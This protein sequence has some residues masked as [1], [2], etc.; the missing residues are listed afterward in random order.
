MPH[1]MQ[2]ACSPTC[3]SPERM[4]QSLLLNHSNGRGC[5]RNGAGR[6]HKNGVGSGIDNKSRNRNRRNCVCNLF[7]YTLW[8]TFYSMGG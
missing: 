2:T 3:T 8:S 1:C 7:G 6:R 4:L 5:H